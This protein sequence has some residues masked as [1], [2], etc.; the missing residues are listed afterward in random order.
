MSSDAPSPPCSSGIVSPNRPSF[1]IPATIWA[2]Y[3]SRCSSSVATGMIS[4]TVKS[5]TVARMSCSNSVRPSVWARR[6]MAGSSGW[7]TGSAGGLRAAGLFPAAL[8]DVGLG[9]HHH[10]AAEHADQ[11]AVLLVA[12]GLDLDDAP[13]GLGRGWPLPE[14]GGLAVDGVAVEGRRHVL[15]R[16]HFQVRDGLARDVRY[17]H[18]EQ[19]RID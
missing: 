1:F 13:V 15:E 19:Q 6:P 8:F 11:G 7:R 9:R 14:H 2:G 4:L 18:A 12:A 16:L 17:R 5:R 3:S 10:L